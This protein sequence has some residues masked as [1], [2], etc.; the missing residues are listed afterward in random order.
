MAVN[1]ID[2]AGSDLN[3]FIMTRAD[4][5]E[6]TVYLRRDATITQVGTP[7]NAENLNKLQS[8]MLAA[9]AA[10]SE[11][12][13]Y[14]VCSQYTTRNND[15]DVTTNLDNF[16]KTKVSLVYLTST[17]TGV[18]LAVGVTVGGINIRNSKEILGEVYINGYDLRQIP[19]R[20]T[21]VC[22]WNKTSFNVLRIDGEYSIDAYGNA[23]YYAKKNLSTASR[24]G[25]LKLTRPASM[26]LNPHGGI[27]LYSEDINYLVTPRLSSGNNAFIGGG[28][29]GDSFHW[30][31]NSEDDK[32][33]GVSYVVFGKIV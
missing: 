1:F 31:G 10:Q 26:R 21:I 33:L 19:S 6:E 12:V 5:T 14:G 22:L 27:T 17:L 2:E 20:A 29:Y 24:S 7:L 13:Y 11:A 4:G 18:A 8:D 28:V 3:K 9:I 16:D 23:T 15:I 25:T 30:Y 32:L